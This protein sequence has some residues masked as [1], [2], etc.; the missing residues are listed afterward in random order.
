M[1]AVEIFNECLDIHLEIDSYFKTMDKLNVAEFD[2]YQLR[3]T[4]FGFDFKGK[5]VLHFTNIEAARL[6]LENNYLRGS[7]FNQ[8]DDKF[9]IIDILNKINENLTSNWA[10]IKAKTFAVSFTEKT[11]N[12]VKNNYKYHWQKFGNKHRG[13]VLEFEFTD[14]TLPYGF[15]PLRINY[16]KEKDSLIKK[17]KNEIPRDLLLEEAEKEFL[18]PLLASIKDKDKF[19]EENEVR[20]M[21][22]ISEPEIENLDILPDS[23]V[24]FSFKENNSINLEL[25]VPFS[26]PKNDSAKHILKLRRIYLGEFFV[27]SNDNISTSLLMRHFDRLCEEKGIELIY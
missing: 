3:G 24:L 21:F 11:D 27:N 7:N 26:T 20:L 19:Q 12:Q 16:I 8:F 2:Y 14:Q 15:Y 17:L 25:R 1:R 10:S 23:N 22:R 9:E 6:I 18:L 13:A 4:N 5:K